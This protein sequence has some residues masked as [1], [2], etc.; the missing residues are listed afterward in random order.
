[1]RAESFSKRALDFTMSLIGLILLV[2]PFTA[3]ALAIR[4][5]SRRPVF[6]RQGPAIAVG[7]TSCYDKG[8]IRSTAG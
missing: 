2:V 7:P 4:L 1:M 8:A 5:D 3:I 6:F